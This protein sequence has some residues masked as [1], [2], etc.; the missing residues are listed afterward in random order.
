EA[1]AAGVRTLGF[2]GGGPFLYAEFVH[3]VCRRAASL[4]FRFD[5]VMTNGVWFADT[6]HLESTLPGVG[7]AG[8]NR[9]TGGGGGQVHGGPTARV[10]EFCRAA[11]R[12]FGR[13]NIVSLSYTS[14]HPDQGLEPVRTLAELLD[15]V[16][17]WSD[18]LGRY[19]LVALDL[20]MTLNWNHLAPVERAE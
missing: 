2:T 12:V 14:R 1:H 19:L 4:G 7:G 17:E 11:R 9:Q 5:K 18:V 8:I 10:A 16:I 3:F 20:T 13:D 15:G 6:P